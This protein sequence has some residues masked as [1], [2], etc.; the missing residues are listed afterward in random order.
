MGLIFWLD[1]GW[2]IKANGRG[3]QDFIYPVLNFKELADDVFYFPISS[4]PF[5]A[6][7]WGAALLRA[8]GRSRACP[9]HFE[10]GTPLITPPSSA[11]GLS[12]HRPCRERSTAAS[13][14]PMTCESPPGHMYAEHQRRLFRCHPADGRSRHRPDVLAVWPPLRPDQSTSRAIR[15]HSRYA[16]RMRCL[17]FTLECMFSVAHAALLQ[18]LFPDDWSVVLRKSLV[19]LSGQLSFSPHPRLTRFLIRMR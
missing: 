13:I 14:T 4:L 10:K 5:I 19:R 9:L 2:R 1:E 11:A 18:I 3:P 17:L 16:V 15:R 8:A 6:S 7:L 12:D